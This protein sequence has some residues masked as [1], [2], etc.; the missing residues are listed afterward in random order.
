M[1]RTTKAFVAVGSVACATLLL[2]GLCSLQGRATRGP[3]ERWLDVAVDGHRVHVLI[4]GNSG[5][6]VV[7]ESGLPG[8]LGWEPVRNAVGQFATVVT[9]DRAGIG[10]SQ[11]GPQPRDARRIAMELR[12]MLR[13]AGLSPPYILVGQSMGGP[14]IRVFAASYPEEVSGLVLVDPTHAELVEPFDDVKAWFA[15]RHTQDWPRVEAITATCSKGMAAMVASGAK[16]AEEFL[17]TL[18]EP[19]R[20]AV[21]GEF[22]SM[23]ESPL[24]GGGSS[25]LSPGARDEFDVLPQSLRQAIDARPLPKVPTILLAAGQPDTYSEASASLSPNLR[26]LNQCQKDWKLND[27][28][29]WVEATPGDKLVIATRS[30]HNIQTERPPLVVNAIRQ[31]IDEA[32][33]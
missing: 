24:K 30:G 12:Q 8:G 10:K 6:T 16:A 23:F 33:R 13:N 27:F 5:P 19:R 26:L 3:R 2:I 15:A 11:P 14:Y 29:R 32:A 18:P 4:V 1:P 20:A 31:V 28:R 21:A 17:D 9:Y 25:D 7:L 22:W